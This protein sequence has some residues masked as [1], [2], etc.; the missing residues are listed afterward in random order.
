MSES[1]AQLIRQLAEVTVRVDAE[2]AEADGWYAGQC[3]GAERAVRDAEQAVRRAESELA[4]AREAAE[5]TDAEVVH[6][7]QTL[8]G[9][10]GAAAGRLG[11]PPVPAAGAPA[12]PTTM[13]D[14]V[15]DLLDRAKHPGDL[16]TSA[17]PLLAIF[18]V[19]GAAVAYALGFA[20]RVAGVQYGGDL[21]VGMPVLGLVVT[22]FGPVVGLAPA[23][24]LADRR[25]AGL[26]PRAVTIVVI[27]GVLTTGTLFALLR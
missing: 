10:L 27:A 19:L 25:H 5:A 21:A 3:A 17:Q 11:A 9:Q 12:D 2:R 14:G 22:L 26:D 15:R 18:G 7:W 24:L 6:L 8:R 20:A 1:Y 23:K 16:P 13:L 4:A